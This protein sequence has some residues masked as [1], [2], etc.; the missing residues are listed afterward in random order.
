MAYGLQIRTQQGLVSTDD[1]IPVR[2]IGRERILISAGTGGANWNIPLDWSKAP[3][4]P[5]YLFL[6]VN[7]VGF[8][9]VLAFG[10]NDNTHITSTPLPSTINFRCA[11]YFTENIVADFLVFAMKV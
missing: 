5:V 8:G 9:N 7:F 10:T 1:V 3:T 2:E 11:S 6:Y 4:L